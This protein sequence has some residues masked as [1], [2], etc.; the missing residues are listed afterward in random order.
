MCQFWL[1]VEI[2]DYCFLCEFV[3]GVGELV[4]VVIVDVIVDCFVQFQWDWFVGFDCQVGDVVLCVDV[5]GGDDCLCWVG[6][7]VGV[8]LVVMC[9]DWFVWW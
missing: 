8:V 9:C 5:I 2:C 1:Y 7:D 3:L 6:I 4:V